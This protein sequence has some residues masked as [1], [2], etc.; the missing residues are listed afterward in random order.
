M[1]QLLCLFLLL[2]SLRVDHGGQSVLA[3]LFCRVLASPLFIF[4]LLNIFASVF[5]ALE[6][7]YRSISTRWYS[8]VHLPPGTVSFTCFSPYVTKFPQCPGRGKR[9]WRFEIMYGF[10]CSRWAVQTAS[11]L[12]FLSLSLLFFFFSSLKE[13]RAFVLSEYSS[14][15]L[16]ENIKYESEHVPPKL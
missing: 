10:T 1:C 15:L 7:C 14:S 11:S 2:V 8:T 9:K 5:C 16:M 12:Y 4:L 6:A 13:K 3:H